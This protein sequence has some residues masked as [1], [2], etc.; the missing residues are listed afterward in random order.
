MESPFMLTA[1]RTSTNPTP[2]GFSIATNNMADEWMSLWKPQGKFEKVRR[3][4]WIIFFRIK[5]EQYTF[6]F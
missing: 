2:L 6:S 4:K 1:E 5:N 3:V